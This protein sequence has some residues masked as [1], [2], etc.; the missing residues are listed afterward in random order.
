MLD[1]EG[2]PSFD[3]RVLG[4]IVHEFCHSFVNPLVYRHNRDL[5][6]AGET[7]FALVEDRM[8]R[9]AYGNWQTMM[10]ESLVRAS[11]VRWDLAT[12]GVAS[13]RSRMGWEEKN[14]FFWISGLSELL[15]E[16]ETQRDTYSD[17]ES[18]FPQIQA[19]FDEYAADAE[20]RIKIITDRWDA[21]R[22]AMAERS[23]KIVSLA[24]ADGAQDVDP[25]LTVIVIT[26]DRPMKD[27]AWGVMRRDGNMPELTGDVFY[28]D[29]RTVF[30]IPVKL[31]PHTDYTVGLNSENA[32]AFQDEKGNPLVPTTFR[33]KTG[34]HR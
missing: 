21:A 31:E 15:G 20:R 33:F 16:Y 3:K 22:A 2:M 28:D 26:F 7:L 1:D 25:A 19:F 17:L 30:T 10:S 32:L 13:A 12:N 23:P 5:E 8:S 18:F 24:P 14:H 11:V 9:Q 4:T 6:A 27:R 29:S 34:P